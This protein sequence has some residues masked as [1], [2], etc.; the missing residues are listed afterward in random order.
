MDL[1][2][3]YQSIKNEIDTKVLEVLNSTAYS[4]GKYVD[5]FESA[6]ASAHNTKYC[7]AVNSGTAALHIVLMAL[8]IGH[9]DEVIVPTNSFF[10]TA[11]AVSLTG[12]TPIFVDCDKDFYNIDCNQIESVITKNTKAII[13][14][15]LYGQPCKVDVLS[16]I[17]KSH[18]LYFVEDCAQAH[19]A[20]YKNTYVGNFGIA[21]C[22]SF[23][24]GKNLGAYGEGGAVTTNDEALYKKL[25]KLRAHGSEK[26]LS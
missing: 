8:N 16:T 2:A 4:G 10:A 6:F 15:H 17:C 5:S 12:A 13:G 21:G 7:V 19:L 23:Y 3:Q 24:P 20:T 1:K 26:I 18:N 9:G 14:V 22:F 11:E 25:C